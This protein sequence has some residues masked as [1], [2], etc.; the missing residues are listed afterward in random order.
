MIIFFAL[1]VD[2]YP[3]IAKNYGYTLMV[4]PV[5]FGLSMQPPHFSG[6]R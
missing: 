2:G 1:E 5:V 6:F 3:K 4:S